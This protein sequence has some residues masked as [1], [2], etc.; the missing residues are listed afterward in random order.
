MKI[1]VPGIEEPPI[2]AEEI[3]TKNLVRVDGVIEDQDFVY[4]PESLPFKVNGDKII[5]PKTDKQLLVLYHRYIDIE[6]P[7]KAEEWEVGELIKI[8]DDEDDE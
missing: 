1:M 4:N 5:L 2:G 6:E 7:T 8:L 3:I